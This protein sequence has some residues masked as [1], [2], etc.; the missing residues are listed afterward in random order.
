MTQRI[1][2]DAGNITDLVVTGDA[3]FSVLVDSGKSFVT[4]QYI[5][6]ELPDATR[7]AFDSWSHGRADFQ[8]LDVDID[9]KVNTL[10][11]RQLGVGF[12]K[13]GKVTQLGD[14]SI[15]WLEREYRIISDGSTRV[16]TNDQGLI[17]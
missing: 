2:L 1:L 8:L 3:G 11:T 5:L 9:L 12:K 4:T 7:Q 10:E 14:A 6:N 17:E 16:L 15:R 13:D